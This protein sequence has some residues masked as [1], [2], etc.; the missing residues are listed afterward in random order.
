MTT[1][2]LPSPLVDTHWLAANIDHPNL[3]I[4]DASSYMPGVPRNAF[5]EWQ[6]QSIPGA[7]FFDFNDKFADTAS[8]LP[9]MLPST[10]VFTQEARQLGIN[11]DSVI[12]AYDSAGIFSSPRAWWMLTAMGHKF[13]AVLDGGL[14]Q[15]LAEARASEPGKQL[16]DEASAVALGNFTAKNQPQNVKN[17]TEISAAIQQ[18]NICILDARSKERFDGG[19]KEPREGL[20]SGHI[21]SSKSLPFDQLLDNG[22]FKPLSDISVL[23]NNKISHDQQLYATCG[24]GITAC[25]LAFAAHL[26][27]V[28]NIAVYD[29]S[30]CEWGDPKRQLPIDTNLK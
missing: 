20:I 8:A 25:V 29:G 22:K 2:M 13:C 6:Q 19:A 1:L 24:S 18:D 15:W 28:T 5:N 10:A 17:A 11:Q 16:S 21:P 12:V 30:W 27:G 23:I 3:I 4:L 9:H 7:R 26:V 14:P